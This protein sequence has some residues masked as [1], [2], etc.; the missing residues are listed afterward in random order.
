MKIQIAMPNML[1][2]LEIW[3]DLYSTNFKSICDHDFKEADAPSVGWSFMWEHFPWRKNKQSHR[4]TILQHI[5]QTARRLFFFVNWPAR[6]IFWVSSSLPVIFFCHLVFSKMSS[7]SISPFV[8]PSKHRHWTKVNLANELN[9]LHLV[10]QS[11][12][13]SPLSGE[14]FLIALSVSPLNDSKG[15]STSFKRHL[16]AITKKTGQK[17]L[18]KQLPSEVYQCFSLLSLFL[19]LAKANCS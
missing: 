10:I 18:N 1:M 3:A 7:I 16:T 13:L 4:P 5:S 12:L 15:C 8:F 17:G 9:L 14:G 2:V 6:K 19:L 11:P